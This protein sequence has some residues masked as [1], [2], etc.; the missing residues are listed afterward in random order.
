MGFGSP[1]AEKEKAIQQFF[2][3]VPAENIH[4]WLTEGV[5]LF[6]H[7]THKIM[8]KWEKKDRKTPSTQ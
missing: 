3:Q 7:F 2:P 1:T 8:E 5:A 4:Q 6:E